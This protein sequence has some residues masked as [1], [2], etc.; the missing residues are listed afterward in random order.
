MPTS[1]L[2]TVV[3]L[4]LVVVSFSSSTVAVSCGVCGPSIFFQ[5]L[6][7]RL[8]STRQD[9]GNAVQ[10]NYETPPISG[11]APACVYSNVNGGLLILVTNAG[12]ACPSTVAVVQEASCPNF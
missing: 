7:R 3:A 10:C 5:G 8:T 2:S 11:I 9:T 6:T 12:G 1:R 4:A